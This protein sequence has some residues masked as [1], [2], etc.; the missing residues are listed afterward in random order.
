MPHPRARGLLS[1]RICLPSRCGP[2]DH[3]SYLPRRELGPFDVLRDG[4]PISLE[5]DPNEKGNT[6]RANDAMPRKVVEI[7]RQINVRNSNVYPSI[8]EYV[9]YFIYFPLYNFSH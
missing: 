8:C 1:N 6:G 3:P 4:K 5:N 2:L 7:L 9:L